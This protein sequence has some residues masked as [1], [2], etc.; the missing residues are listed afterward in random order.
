MKRIIVALLG[1]ICVAATAIF[2]GAF[3]NTKNKVNAAG[4]EKLGGRWY[5]Q[6]SV[7]TTVDK[8]AGD[9]SVIAMGDQQIVE[10]SDKKYLEY[11]YD[12]IAEHAADMNLK[13]YV[14][15]GDI[16][17]VVDFCDNIGGY[18]QNDKNGRNRG[19]DDSN[20]YFWQQQRFVSEQIKKL[21]DASVP[22]ALTMGNHDYEDMAA[23]YRINKT[24]N[25]A[26]PLSR[27]SGNSYFGGSLYEDIEC[28]Y[29][30]FEN[31]FTPTDARYKKYMV[32]VL[33][34][35]PDEEMIAWANKI[36]EENSD[37]KIIVSTHAYFAG[38]QLYDKGTELWNKF[39][40]RHSNIIMTICGHDWV[41]GSI[42][43]RVDYGVNG[44]AVYQFMIN[45][46]GEE[47]GGLG[48][49]AQMIFRADDTVDLAYYAPA[50]DG[51]A[52][53]LVTLDTQ[54]RYFTENSQFSFDLAMKK[55]SLDKT[56]ETLVGNEVKS[57]SIKE[58]YAAYKAN[59][60]RWLKD[61]YAYK[62]V[63]I[64]DG[65]GLVSDGTGYI[66]YKLSAGDDRRFKGLSVHTLGELTKGARNAYQIDL[67]CDGENYVTAL[68]NDCFTGTLGEVQYMDSYARGARDLY[69]KIYLGENGGARIS[70]ISFTGETVQTVF[71]DT[72][73]INYVYSDN[74]K[75][76]VSNWRD[77]VYD[78]LDAVYFNGLLGSGGSY[79][80]GKYCDHEG[81]K[82]NIVYR[83]ESGKN[84][85][86]TSLS[87]GVNIKADDINRTYSFNARHV[88]HTYTDADGKTVTDEADIPGGEY[89]FKNKDTL[90]AL[91]VWVSLDGGEYVRVAS[92]DNSEINGVKDIG[93]DLSTYIAGGKDLLV[94][95]EYFGITWT[96]TAINNVSIQA[97]TEKTTADEPTL[98]L[99]GGTVYGENYENP[100]KDGY[101]FGG[102]HIGSVDGEL[103]TVEAEKGKAV[104]LYAKWL[105]ISRI[106]YVMDGGENSAENP[107][108]IVE[109]ENIKL[110]DP[111]K[112]G[113]EFVGWFDEN[114]LKTDS[115]TSDGRLV[116][117]YAIWRKI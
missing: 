6:T 13:M 17:D 7:D 89:P 8:N 111:E 31:D 74:G 101:R 76:N 97:D 65:A 73:D 96:G 57:S 117:V 103:T 48:V 36:A 28:A 110:S 108:I 68:Y 69:V 59:N 24:F 38:N 27:F 92:Y 106:V 104:E 46:Q 83:I 62:N 23:S 21:E 84:N 25:E 105:K 29:Y 88:S 18:N 20:K 61:V 56:G 47:F 54:G 35:N 78:Y 45:T 22:V 71:G 100:V 52:S 49:F 55:L 14:N 11:S 90:Y 50:V 33:G 70:S 42:I 66:V 114:G 44:N 15:L 12:Y 109:G 43:K 3:V 85:K 79:K 4:D 94:K 10:H 41:D 112:S 107:T 63:K 40:S 60:G 64:K 30:Y 113:Y 102:W 34:L 81:G 39:I 32:L 86:F 72:V 98:N 115:V 9:F 80:N 2:A 95:L 75:Y 87:L 37:R 1:V 19:A 51:Y 116:V 77:G 16:F 99:N 53:E 67:S 5:K 82:A 91:R 93:L 58:N 26:F